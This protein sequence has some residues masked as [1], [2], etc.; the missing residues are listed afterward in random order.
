MITNMDMASKLGSIAVVTK[1]C[2][3]REKRMVKA[4]ILG[5]TAAT[6]METG[7]ITKSQAMGS[8]YGLMAGSSRETG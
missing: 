8:T 3:N 6:T 2:I 4:N 7:W 5:K 1:A